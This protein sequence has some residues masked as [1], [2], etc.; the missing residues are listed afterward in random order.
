MHDNRTVYRPSAANLTHFLFVVAAS[1]LLIIKKNSP[2]TNT[3]MT[4]PVRSNKTKKITL[5]FDM[6]ICDKSQFV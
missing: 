4:F 1:S 5:P 2:T 6:Q 3:K